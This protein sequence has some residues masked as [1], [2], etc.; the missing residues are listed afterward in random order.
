MQNPSDQSLNPASSRVMI[1][2]DDE[3]SRQLHMDMMDAEFKVVTCSSG[4]EALEQVDSFK[5]DLILLDAAMPEM[6]G[7]EAC[8]RIRQKYIDLPIIFITAYKSLD[9][10]LK[11]YD[12]GGDD[13]I[14]KPVD[15]QILLRKAKH[16]IRLKSEKDRLD[17]EARSMHDLVFNFVSTS[18]ESSILLNFVRKGGKAT[19]HDSLAQDLVDAAKDFGVDCCVLLHHPDGPKIYTSHGEP[20]ELEREI[21][22]RMSGMGRLVEF[23]RQFIVNYDRLSIMITT[24][25]HEAP[26]KIRRIR[27][28]TVILAESAEGLCELMTLRVESNARTEQMQVALL[29]ASSSI[30][31]VNNSHAHLMADTRV[32]LY[33]L[34]DKVE[35]TY[36]WLNTSQ[37]QEEAIS[38]SMNQSIDE[39]LAL[40]TAGNKFEEAISKVLETLNVENKQ[41]DNFLF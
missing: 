8:R 15:Q 2:D 27:D 37:S 33:K 30:E 13:L 7:Y 25:P 31:E 32:L 23:K 19:S 26:E 1:V 34:V 9:E 22:D 4:S 5:P 28:N 38:S 21:M 14:T 16:S 29:S 11:A 12:S 10:H 17:L 18:G 39:I 24:K 41:N 20:T 35:A 6:D 3:F 36:S 40:L